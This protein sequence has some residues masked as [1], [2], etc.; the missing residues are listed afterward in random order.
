ME[1]DFGKLVKTCR[2]RAKLSQEVFADLMHTTQSTISRIEKNLI[3]VEA[4]FLMKAAKVTNS[5]DIVISSIFSVDAIMQAAQLVPTF[6]GGF[7]L[8]I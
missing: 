1:V 3:A 7:S 5:E 4:R 2:K 8:W 6:I